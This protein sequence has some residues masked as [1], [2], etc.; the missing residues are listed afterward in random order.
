M[1]WAA[2]GVVLLAGFVRVLAEVPI[3]AAGEK[4]GHFDVRDFRGT[5]IATITEVRQDD[6]TPPRLDFCSGYTTIVADGRGRAAVDS[7]EKCSRSGMFSG[8]GMQLYDVEPDGTLFLWEGEQPLDR[9]H[10]RI[11]EGGRMILCDGSARQHPEVFS[12][13]AIGVRQSLRDD[14]ICPA[15]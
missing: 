8:C 13:Q 7:T 14:A 9:V 5:Y 6:G 1:I 15:D 2:A 12:F 11:V 4:R 10:C 3:D